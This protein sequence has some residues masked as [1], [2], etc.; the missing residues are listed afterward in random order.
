MLQMIAKVNHSD[1]F[2]ETDQVSD[3]S[4][5]RRRTYVAQGTR[6]RLTVAK[7]ESSN[8]FSNLLVLV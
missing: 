6:Q 4:S 2:N 8:I 1:A 7:L 5:Q 3:E